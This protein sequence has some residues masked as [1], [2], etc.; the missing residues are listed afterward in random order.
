MKKTRVLI[1]EDEQPN[2]ERLQRLLGSLRPEMEILPIIDSVTKA[3]IW[4]NKNEIPDLIMMDVRLS[5]GLSFEIFN[6]IKIYCPIIFTTA[7]DE[8]A[9]KAFKY[10][11]VDYLLKPIEKEELQ[12][13]L[14]EFEQINRHSSGIIPAIENLLGYFKQKK[15]RNRF[16]IPY[17][18]TYKTV[19]V[20]NILYFVSEFNITTAMLL[21]GQSEIIPHTLEQ[22][23]QELDPKL[24]FRINRQYIVHID[25]IQKIHNYF[26][27]KLKIGLKNNVDPEIFVSRKKAFLLKDWIGY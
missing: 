12:I 1:L 6:Q 19:F 17:K 2:A 8:Y 3:I 10:N 11:S 24:F 9:V 26:N 22:L 13:A 16:L 18:D 14:E 27:G 25:S 4:L 21:D 5:D 20:N 7:Y 15:Y 23:E